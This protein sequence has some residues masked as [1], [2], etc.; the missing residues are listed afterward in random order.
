MQVFQQMRLAAD[1]QLAVVAGAARP[2]GDAGGDYFL[3]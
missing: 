2:A 1:D 3:R